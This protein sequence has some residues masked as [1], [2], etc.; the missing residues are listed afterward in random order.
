MGEYLKKSIYL[1][2][3]LLIDLR[4]PEKLLSSILLHYKSF[5]TKN[6]EHKFMNLDARDYH[7]HTST[8]SD[9]LNSIDELVQFA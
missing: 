9:G 4:Q 6:I 5:M 8:F 1:K 3:L 2:P 7:M